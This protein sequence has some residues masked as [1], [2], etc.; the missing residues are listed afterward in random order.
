MPTGQTQ[1][2]FGLREKALEPDS[3]KDIREML[4][5]ATRGTRIRNHKLISGHLFIEVD[6]VRKVERTDRW[7]Y[8]RNYLVLGEDPHEAGCVTAMYL[9]DGPNP[10]AW[11]TH[12]KSVTDTRG[13]VPEVAW[14]SSLQLRGL[15]KSAFNNQNWQAIEQEID[16][17]KY[18]LPARHR[19]PKPNAVASMGDDDTNDDD[20]NPGADSDDDYSWRDDLDPLNRPESADP[21]LDFQGDVPDDDQEVVDMGDIDDHVHMED[22]TI[23]T[24][25]NLFDPYDDR[26]PSPTFVSHSKDSPPEIITTDSLDDDD[27]DMNSNP[28][29]DDSALDDDLVIISDFP[30]Q[31]KLEPK[32]EPAPEL[33][34][35]NKIVMLRST[36]NFIDLTG[37]PDN[38]VIDLTGFDDLIV[39]RTS[40]GVEIIELED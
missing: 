37:E 32:V 17:H 22:D 39:N 15:T 9:T 23:N 3:I 11:T 28:I 10:M 29:R 14:C 35:T 38:E 36:N 21:D 1:R 30:K 19:G 12:M 18:L 5:P 33:T 8:V 6:C 16:R 25:Q 31:P 7:A 4:N 26:L 13:G 27:I 20:E 24:N 2:R 34:T 40:S